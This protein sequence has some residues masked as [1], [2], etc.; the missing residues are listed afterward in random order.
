MCE[1][2]VCTK[3]WV[4]LNGTSG[5]VAFDSH[6]PQAGDVIVAV[7]GGWDWGSSELNQDSA[8]GFWRILK[9][10]KVSQ[11]D[12]T[13]FTSPEADSDPQHPSPYLQYRSFYIDRSKI[14]D[15]TLATYW[16]DDTRT[17]PFITMNYSIVDL[18]AVKTQRAPVAF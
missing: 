8:H 10:P 7:D 6:M 4:D 17:Q 14:T 1:I 13:Q 2:L 9:L 11:S 15:P 18:L 12:A 16:D 5:N 3:G